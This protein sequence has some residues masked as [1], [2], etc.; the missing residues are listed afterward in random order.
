MHGNDWTEV[1]HELDKGKN[2][3]AIINSPWYEDAV[4]PRFSV[5][6]IDRRHAHARDLM[7]REGLDALLLTGGQNVYS[8]GSGVT[9]ASGMMDD[10]GMIQYMILPR[11][12]DPTV[13]YPHP[14][15][16]I[17]AVRRMTWVDDVRGCEGGRYGRVIARRL[18]EL[19]IESGRIGVTAADRTGPEYMGVSAYLELVGEL[20]QLEIS[21]EPDLFHE[22][23]Y[24]KSAEEIAA[25]EVAGELA[26]AAQHALVAA[27]VPG[28]RECDLS[29]QATAAML[30]GGGRSFLMMVGSTDT[31]DPKLIFPNPNPSMRVLGQGDLILP[32]LSA[33]YMGYS[34]KVGHPVSVGE[35]PAYIDAFYADVLGPAYEEISGAL[36]PD[37]PLERVHEATGVFRRLG[38]QSRPMCM[39]GIDLITDGPIVTTDGVRA[40]DLDRVLVPGMTVNVE[41][42]PIDAEGV[43]GMF[44]SRTFVIEESGA[45]DITPFPRDGVVRGG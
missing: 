33:T 28:N 31:S 15:C 16:H 37:V 2:F 43:Y 7:E 41:I 8:M 29:A 30:A 3:G 6:E 34:A 18:T 35:P 22:L 1:R 19:G 10:R 21:F 5:E 36:G 26:V 12:G 14:G 24:R 32:E 27:A 38:A 44:M 17:E 23:T 13:F 25:M 11:V 4:Y 45:R 39:H 9:W 40:S 20:P 42:T